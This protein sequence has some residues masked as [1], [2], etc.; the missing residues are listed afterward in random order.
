[1]YNNYLVVFSVDQF[2]H[3]DNGYYTIIRTDFGLDYLSD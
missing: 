1:M 3:L 2:K